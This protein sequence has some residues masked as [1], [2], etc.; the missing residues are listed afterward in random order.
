MSTALLEIPGWY[1]E[2]QAALLRQAPRPGE[3]DQITAERWTTNQ[4]GLK[5]NLAECL[6]PRPV[7]H[8]ET[9]RPEP[10][11]PAEPTEKFALLADLGIITVPDDYVHEKRLTTF[12]KKNR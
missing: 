3:I 12:G 1:V 8:L 11:A 4:K 5:K 6:V 7:T 10:T 2:F 9:V